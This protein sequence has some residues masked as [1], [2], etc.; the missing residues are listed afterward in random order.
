MSMPR[1]TSQS[2]SSALHRAWLM[3]TPVL[4]VLGIQRSC[5]RASPISGSDRIGF[6][7]RGTVAPHRFRY[8]A[9]RAHCLRSNPHSSPQPLTA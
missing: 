2:S 4:I 8:Q 5:T 7:P 9:R 1:S 6:T 3:R